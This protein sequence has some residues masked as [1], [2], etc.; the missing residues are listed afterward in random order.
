MMHHYPDLGSAS[1]WLSKFSANKKH[2]PDLGRVKSSVWNFCTYL[3]EVIWEP[4]VL[5]QN[6]SCF[7]RLKGAA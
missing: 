7:L 2:F 5:S 1:D 3:S 6:V 4:V